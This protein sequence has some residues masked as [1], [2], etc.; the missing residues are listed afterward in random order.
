[1]RHMT[2]RRLA[3]LALSLALAASA[4]SDDGEQSADTTSPS[5]TPSVLDT[6]P[7]SDGDEC[8]DP[9]GDLST[10]AA[11]EGVGSEPAGV[12]LVRGAALVEGDELAVRFETAGSIA[13]LVDPL[14]VVGQ[15]D[16]GGSLSF[17]LRAESDLEGNWTLTLIKFEPDETRVSIP[18]PVTVDGSTLTFRVPLSALPPIG[19]Y[20]SFGATAEAAGVGTVLDDCSSLGA[21][22]TTG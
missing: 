1:M 14:F 17:E 2:A 15:G 19:L 10:G 20:M 3:V 13:S 5:P 11:V 16:A 7:S 4:C 6:V 8:V 9:T 22:P 18:N 21:P 12:D